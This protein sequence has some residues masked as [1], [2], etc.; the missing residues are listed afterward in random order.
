MELAASPANHTQ[1]HTHTLEKM[2]R[3]TEVTQFQWFRV[4]LGEKRPEPAVM[5]SVPNLTAFLWL[6]GYQ[7]DER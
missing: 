4:M 3:Y 6:R 2:F 1:I 7:K 5:R